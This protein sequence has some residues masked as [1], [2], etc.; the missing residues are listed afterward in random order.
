MFFFELVQDFKIYENYLDTNDKGEQ[1][2][3]LPKEFLSEE[4]VITMGELWQ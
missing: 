3:R 2:L 1:N 4:I